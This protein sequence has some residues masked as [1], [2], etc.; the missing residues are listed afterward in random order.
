MTKVLRTAVERQR[1]PFIF[2]RLREMAGALARAV[3]TIKGDFLADCNPSVLLAL[4][5]FS[6]SRKSTTSS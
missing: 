4:V 3:R 2:G 6:V 1:E 5:F